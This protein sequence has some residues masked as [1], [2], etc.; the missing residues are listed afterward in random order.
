M[1][2][3][4]VEITSTDLLSL[5]KAANDLNE[6]VDGA[7]SKRWATDCGPRLRDTTEWCRFYTALAR[8]NRDN[9]CIDG[10]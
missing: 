2:C 10:K 6:I 5:V 8:V 3:N 1:K 7:R 9:S 4:G